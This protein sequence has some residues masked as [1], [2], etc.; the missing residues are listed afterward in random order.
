M[1]RQYTL[2]LV[3]AVLAVSASLASADF[4]NGT[5]DTDTDWTKVGTAGIA[6]GYATLGGGGNYRGAV[7]QT[8]TTTAGDWYKV[9]YDKGHAGSVNLASGLMVT[10][11]DGTGNANDDAYWGQSHVAPDKTGVTAWFQA[12]S[13]TT[14]I[15]FRDFNYSGAS[16]DV[17]VDNASVVTGTVGVRDE[18]NIAGSAALSQSSYYD[19]GTYPAAYGTDGV[20]DNFMHTA[21]VTGSTYTLTFAADQAITRIAISARDGFLNRTGNALYLY[22][23]SDALIDTVT[24]NDGYYNNLTNATFRYWHGVRKIVVE[25]TTASTALNFAE[26]EVYTSQQVNVAPLGTAIA[27]SQYSTTSWLP[28]YA[29]DESTVYGNNAPNNVFHS[30]NGGGGD[31]WRLDLDEGYTLKTVEIQAR[32]GSA[33]YLDRMGN[34][35]QFLDDNGDVLFTETIVQGDAVGGLWTL[36]GTWAGVFGVRITDPDN[37]LNLAEVRLFADTSVAPIPEPATMSLLAM[38]ALAILRRRRVRS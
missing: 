11:F 34:T 36:N 7:Y 33:G 4:V 17:R 26:I 1:T 5:F 10:A 3:G 18:I 20:A 24:V 32:T 6:S 14:T 25:D 29:V 21:D 2:G 35:L 8:I 28:Q 12:Q 15:Q 30:G 19:I 38:G 23:A 22:D 13:N 9:T 16:H 37:Y 27:S 31:W